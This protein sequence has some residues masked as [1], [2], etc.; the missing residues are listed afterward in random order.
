M[1]DEVLEIWN[2][3]PL[4]TTIMLELKFKINTLGVLQ[5]NEKIRKHILDNYGKEKNDLLRLPKK[6]QRRTAGCSIGF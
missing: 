5:N 1:K 4:K 2:S 3:L 6:D